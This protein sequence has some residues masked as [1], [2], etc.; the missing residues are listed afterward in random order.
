[1]VDARILGS[2]Y[3]YLKPEGGYA[4]KPDAPEDVKKKFAIYKEAIVAIHA[5]ARGNAGRKLHR[6]TPSSF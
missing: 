3:V 6:D 5:A 2:E 1:M 4:L